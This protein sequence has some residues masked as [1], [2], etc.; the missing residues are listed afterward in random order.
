MVNEIFAKLI[1]AVKVY[2]N[3]DCP[4]Y[5]KPDGTCA[6]LQPTVLNMGDDRPLHLL[7]PV[8]YSQILSIIPEAKQMGR[9]IDAFLVL[10]VYGE[11]SERQMEYL[12]ME[13]AQAQ[14]IPLWIGEENRKKFTT[15]T[16]K[17][18]TQANLEQKHQQEKNIINKAQ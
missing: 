18:R 16:N 2:L 13:L 14:V 10:M 7:F 15:V 11:V 3:K 5:E 9:E 8:H 6:I 1:E 17:L 4:W 12:I